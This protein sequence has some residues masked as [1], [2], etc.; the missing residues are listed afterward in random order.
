MN[1]EFISL[2]KNLFTSD[3]LKKD[4]SILNIFFENQRTCSFH[5][6]VITDNEEH[7]VQLKSSFQTVVIDKLEELFDFIDE[8]CKVDSDYDIVLLVNLFSFYKKK[9]VENILQAF[10]NSKK[11]DTHYVFINEIIYKNSLLNHPL[12]FMR[13]LLFK[14]TDSNYGR[15]VSLNEVYSMLHRNAFQILDSTRIL[16]SNSIPTYPIEYFLITTQPIPYTG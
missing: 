3:K 13:N 8:A 10:S 7:I 9:E 5:S 15:S 6:R 4:S 11:L 2:Y 16:N 12:S 14:F 1:I